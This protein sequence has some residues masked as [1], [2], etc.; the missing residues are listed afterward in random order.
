M[1]RLVRV[2]LF[3]L[4]SVSTPLLNQPVSASSGAID[5]GPYFFKSNDTITAV[6]IKNN[7]LYRRIMLP[8]NFEGIRSMFGFSFDY[9]DLAKTFR[10]SPEFRQ[11]F[12]NADSIC[13]ISDIHGNFS[14]YITL[15]KGA[16]VIDE[17]LRWKFG[18]GHLVILGDIFDRGEKVTEIMWHVFDLE[19]QAAGAGGKV[20]VI[21]GNHELM[22]LSDDLRYINEKYRVTEIITGLSYSGLF[23][24]S[25][26]LGKWL[27]AKPV[28]VTI[29]DILFIHGG[30]SAEMVENGLKVKDINEVFY[31][32]LVAKEPVDSSQIINLD[33]LIGDK[34]PLWYR[35]F[36]SETGIND[37]DLDKILAFYDVNHIIVGHTPGNVIRSVNNDKIF[38]IDA[39]ITNG[40]P[41]ELLLI[42]KGEFFR[43]DCSGIRTKLRH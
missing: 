30:I 26:V 13:V 6:W 42:K 24:G 20:H 1:K 5:D 29:N 15:L 17:N 9:N 16:S 19:K 12:T 10:Q 25:S 39:G 21:L 32:D 22:V 11:K 28:V 34:G 7:N 35:G 38:G 36:F 43:V 41:G 14:S 37:Q 8:D 31:N 33:L 3:I 18:K 2:I 4:F 27:R 23:S 40:L